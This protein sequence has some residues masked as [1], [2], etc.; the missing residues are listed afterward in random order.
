MKRLN[1]TMKE[2]RK[3]IQKEKKFLGKKKVR[4]VETPPVINNT[5]NFNF[6][7]SS[8]NSNQPAFPIKKEEVT[9]KIKSLSLGNLETIIDKWCC[10]DFTLHDDMLKNLENKPVS[11]TQQLSE[12]KKNTNNITSNGQHNKD[13]FSS[14]IDQLNDLEAL[15]QNTKKD[16]YSNISGQRHTSAPPFVK[17]KDNQN[18]NVNT[19]VTNNEFSSFQ[20]NLKSIPSVRNSNHESSIKQLENN[21]SE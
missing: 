14:L 1:S 11:I 10:N 3:M 6:N 12:I 19:F 5:V 8:G 7:I 21:H 13:Y 4:A 18:N 20:S 16:I 17:N 15:L 9:E 2:C